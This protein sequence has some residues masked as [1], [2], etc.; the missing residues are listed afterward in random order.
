M[1]EMS[2][3]FVNKTF[4]ILVMNVHTDRTINVWKYI[5]SKLNSWQSCHLFG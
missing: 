5:F 1:S 2:T 4:N 3:K